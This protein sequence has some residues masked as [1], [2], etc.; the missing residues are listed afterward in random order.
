MEDQIIGSILIRKC[1]PI[2]GKAMLTDLL[3]LV[4]TLSTNP[5]F[6]VRK[7]VAEGIGAFSEVLGCDITQNTLLPLFTTLAAGGCL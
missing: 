5:S 6:R 3:P 7:E 4:T 1:A 2:I